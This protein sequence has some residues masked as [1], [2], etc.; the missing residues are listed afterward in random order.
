MRLR[1]RRRGQEVLLAVEEQVEAQV[2]NQAEMSFQKTTR[3]QATLLL[4]LQNLR[5]KKL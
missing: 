3:R 4:T 1:L 2:V 5:Q